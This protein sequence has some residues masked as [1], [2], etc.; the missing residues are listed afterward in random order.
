MKH[1]LQIL[2]VVR[3]SI[4]KKFYDDKDVPI[5]RNLV[6]GDVSREPP[7]DEM[8]VISVPTASTV[9]KINDW[10]YF[11]LHTS[12]VDKEQMK[13]QVEFVADTLG[14]ARVPNLEFAAKDSR[15]AHLM[16]F[17][18]EFDSF[19]LPEHTANAVLGPRSVDTPSGPKAFAAD[20]QNALD[21]RHRFNINLAGLAHADGS[22]TWFPAANDLVRHGDSGLVMRVPQSYADDT[23]KEPSYPSVEQD[24][25]LRLLAPSYF[26][27]ALDLQDDTAWAAWKANI[28]N[29]PAPTEASHKGA[30][31][32]EAVEQMA[33]RVLGS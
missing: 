25:L 24:A 2:L 20:G 16:P 29:V 32:E 26:C 5:Y 27:A 8:E 22:V 15:Q 31:T 23:A 19:H 4:W 14:L 33:K 6:Y 3:N 13:A 30:M 11:G 28:P 18:P 1:G 7:P 17:L 12:G 10:I 9:L 21:L